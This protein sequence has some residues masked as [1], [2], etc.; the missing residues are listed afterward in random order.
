MRLEKGWVTFGITMFLLQLTSLVLGAME[1]VSVL[2]LVMFIVGCGLGFATLSRIVH[3]FTLSTNTRVV[4]YH[5]QH[6][7]G[8]KAEKYLKEIL[9]ESDKP[10]V[11]KMDKELK[12][13]HDILEVN[14]TNEV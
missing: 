8:S 2:L 12:E 3:H 4:D 10:D 9:K 13:L 6:D 1:V 11:D 14:E 5:V 7:K